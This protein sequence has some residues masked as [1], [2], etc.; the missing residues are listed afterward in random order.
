MSLCDR[1]LKLHF[2]CFHNY[3]IVAVHMFKAFNV[4]QLQV[5]A[6]NQW[7]SFITALISQ[8]TWPHCWLIEV[9]GLLISVVGKECHRRKLID[10]TFFTVCLSHQ[11]SCVEALHSSLPQIVRLHPSLK[12]H[13]KEMWTSAHWQLTE[14]WMSP[15]QAS[16]KHHTDL[17]NREKWTSKT[18]EKAESHSEGSRRNW[19]YIKIQ[20][21]KEKLRQEENGRE[22]VKHGQ[23]KQT[24]KLRIEKR[25]IEKSKENQRTYRPRLLKKTAAQGSYFVGVVS[26]V[27]PTVTR[28][29]WRGREEAGSSASA[30]G[31]C[32]DGTVSPAVDPQGSRAGSLQ[33]NLSP[34]RG[35]TFLFKARDLL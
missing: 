23:L 4:K 14:Q 21:E 3:S 19:N 31:R 15:E 7:I 24:V 28:P 29:G 10:I 17:E 30:L 9:S 18:E 12:R 27:V 32:Q 20:R 22:I 25:E 33:V 8:V 13:F 2:F 34:T 35:R 16:G 5:V 26:A 6:E 11:L 1:T